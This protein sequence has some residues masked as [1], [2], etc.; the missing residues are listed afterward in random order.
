ML[1]PF[2]LSKLVCN[3]AGGERDT[4]RRPGGAREWRT[5]RKEGKANKAEEQQED[6]ELGAG[7]GHCPA[8]L[9]RGQGQAQCSPLPPGSAN[10]G[11][12]CP[13]CATLL[14]QHASIATLP[15]TQPRARSC[16]FISSRGCRCQEPPCHAPRS[17]APPLG[18][19]PRRP[20]AHWLPGQEGGRSLAGGGVR[21]ALSGWADVWP[22]ARRPI[23]GECEC[24]ERRRRIPARCGRPR[25]R[26]VLWPPGNPLRGTGDAG[27]G[28]ELS[29]AGVPAAGCVRCGNNARKRLHL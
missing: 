22:G 27:R 5:G 21:R 18:T 3:Q 12:I 7:L 11:Q 24:G 29:W 6:P 8:S 1:V 13:S 16:P 15:C 23:A 19:P 14:V 20:S 26:A 4:G 2:T 25:A 10:P 9:P 28:R 17:P